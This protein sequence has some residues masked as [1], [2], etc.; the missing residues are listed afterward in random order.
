MAKKGG[1][2]PAP[3][4]PIDPAASAKAQAE[5]N[6]VSQITP[7]G[8]LLFGTLK[9]GEDGGYTVDPNLSSN[10][11]ASTVIETPFQK[12]FRALGEDTGLTLANQLAGQVSNLPAVSTEGLPGYVSNL[13]FSGLPNLTNDFSADRDKV[14][15]AVYQRGLNRLTPEY[16]QAERRLLTRLATQGIP[17]GS[18]A[19][20][21]ATGEYQRNRDT[22]LENI[23]F[24]AIT[25]GGAEQSRLAGLAAA[26]R[27]QGVSEQLS[28]AQLAAAARTG[29]LGE[30]SALRSGV[31]QELA[32]IIGGQAYNPSPTSQFFAPGGVDVLG[33]QQLAQQANIANAN[34]A[35]QN[36]QSQNAGLFG[37]GSALAGSILPAAALG[38]WFA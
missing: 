13:D 1:S 5:A 23:G 4:T 31:L 3:I 2:A 37:I 20:N 19:Y 16:D 24:D 38:K 6:R 34:Y 8:S 14:E 21:S 33:A 36:Q 7:A 10:Q 12:E 15:N 26:A 29:G 9:Q 28:N 30:Q 35:A 17:V 18:E 11:A 22:A 32:S 27:G 25:A